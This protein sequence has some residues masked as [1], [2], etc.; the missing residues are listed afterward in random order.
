[1]AREISQRMRRL[2]IEKGS[3]VSKLAGFGAGKLLWAARPNDRLRPALTLADEGPPGGS[4]R[5]RQPVGGTEKKSAKR[6][7]ASF[8]NLF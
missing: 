8:V 7:R 2:A 3:A 1:M 4:Y 6:R 5:I